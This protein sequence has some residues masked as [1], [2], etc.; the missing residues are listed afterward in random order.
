M[1]ELGMMGRGEHAEIV[2]FVGRTVD[3]ELSGNMTTCAGG[4]AHEQA[5]PL[6][7]AHLGTRAQEIGESARQPRLQPH[8]AG[9][10]EQGHARVAAGKRG[11][12]RMLAFD[13]DRFAYEGLNCAERLTQPMLKVAGQWQEV[14]WQ[15]A[16]AAVA[17]GLK[18]AQT[19]YG[20][21]ALGASPRRI[22]R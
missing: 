12:E 20:P 4:R 19:L 22:P 21:Q 7:R 16:L 14:D 10:G 11:A 2:S 13:R 6:Q 18:N 3:S 8:R 15:Q 9:D 17:T 1:M 5:V